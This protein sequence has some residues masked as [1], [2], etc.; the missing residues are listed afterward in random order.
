MTVPHAVGIIGAIG[1]GKTTA[2]KYLE[3]TY[4][5]TRAP[6]AGP[7]KAMLKT[8]GLTEEQVNG[9]LKEVPCGLLFGRTPRHAMQTLGTEWRNLIHPELWTNIWLKDYRDYTWVP[10]G[11][12]RLVADD[13]RFPHEVDAVRSVGG[14]ILKIVRPGHAV[15][16]KA[17]SHGSEGNV[18]PFDHLIVND[19]D[20]D[21]LYRRIDMALRDDGCVAA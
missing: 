9:T 12:L 13:V 19:V 3:S 8:M 20:V 21:T 18:L 7:L 10:E 11:H 1:A 2:A 4:A 5:F 16:N 14:V 6:F 17:A 15:S